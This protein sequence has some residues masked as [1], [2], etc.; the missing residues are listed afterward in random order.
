MLREGRPPDDPG[1]LKIRYKLGDSAPYRILFEKKTVEGDSNLPI[2]KYN[3]G[4]E[5][6]SPVIMAGNVQIQIFKNNK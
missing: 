4:K 5:L 2:N 3:I 1:E 6:E